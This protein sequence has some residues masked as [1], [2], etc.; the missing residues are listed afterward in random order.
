M[1]TATKKH[2]HQSGV[3]IY[4]N[5][6]KLGPWRFGT[7]KATVAASQLVPA[8]DRVRE[9]R[10]HSAWE[11][12]RSPNTIQQR[13]D[14]VS[15]VREHIKI[16]PLAG[17]HGLDVPQETRPNPWL[18][19]S[20]PFLYGTLAVLYAIALALYVG[21]G[22]K[23]EST[24]AKVNIERSTIGVPLRESYPHA[25]LTDNQA[26]QFARSALRSTGLDLSDWRVAQLWRMSDREI[27][28]LFRHDQDYFQ[29]VEITV[30][31]EPEEK[32]IVC[33]IYPN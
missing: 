4:L 5:I 14:R 24:K 3:I 12:A 32:R 20:R 25:T 19:A 1:S 23:P 31:L 11:P 28:V 13:S 10:E 2:S 26:Q 17:E 15:A 16:S 30:K 21:V 29:V 33:T 6:M 18:Q 7:H 9:M 27:T 8:L 22:V